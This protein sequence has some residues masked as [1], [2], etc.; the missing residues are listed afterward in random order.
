LLAFFSFSCGASA[1]YLLNDLADLATDRQHPTKCRRPFAAGSIPLKMGFP[2]M[3]ACLLGAAFPSLFLPWRYSACLAVYLICTIAYTAYC[4]GLL[5]LDVV[6]LAGMYVLRIIAGSALL[7]GSVSNW[8]LAFALFLFLGLALLKRIG[9]NIQHD[10]SGQV[11]GRAYV[12]S[13]TGILE[14]M[15][16]ASGFS[17]MLVSAL[18]IDS[19]Q[20]ARLYTHPQVLWLLCPLFIYWYGRLLLIT[21]RGGMGDDPLAYA[22]LDRNSWLCVAC[23]TVLLLG[24]I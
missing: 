11:P 7:A 8:L 4:K 6:V 5:M 2:C 16:A 23:G 18:Y 10:A 19:L 14:N 24:A 17:A 15:A 22:L 3:A 20:A 1:I 9:D 12:F 21:H 13:D